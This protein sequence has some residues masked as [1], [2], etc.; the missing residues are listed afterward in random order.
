MGILFSFFLAPIHA[1][2]IHT[3]TQPNT[4][5]NYQKKKEIIDRI[6]EHQLLVFDVTHGWQPLCEFLNKQIPENIPFP[7]LNTNAEFHRKITK[8][9]RSVIYF[10]I[11]F[12][13]LALA[14]AMGINYLK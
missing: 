8:S 13:V 1:T 7:R 5:T 14:I 10:I 2:N 9:V 6:P 12:W 11:A 3:H 4:F